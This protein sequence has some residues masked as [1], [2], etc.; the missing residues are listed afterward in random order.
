MFFVI[1]WW[2]L[3]SN[4]TSMTLLNGLLNK[5]VQC[6]QS[7]RTLITHFFN[8]FIFL[9]PGRKKKGPLWCL[10]TEYRFN[11]IHSKT[12]L[13]LSQRLG[14][15]SR[16][17][18]V[19][20]KLQKMWEELRVT[21]ETWESLTPSILWCHSETPAMAERS[22]NYDRHRNLKLTVSEWDSALSKNKT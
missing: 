7:A 16:P 3:A 20:L 18:H 9:F 22:W 11:W 6:G 10:T 5:R 19:G 13:E 21:L 17:W 2:G 8:A 12:S 1:S 14:L 15:I 4:G